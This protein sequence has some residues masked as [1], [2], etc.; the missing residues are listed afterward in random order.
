M[1]HPALLGKRSRVLT[2]DTPSCLPS[3]AEDGAPDLRLRVE[4]GHPDLWLDAGDVF[5]RDFDVESDEEIGDALVVEAALA[6]ET[7]FVGEHGD[8][9][10]GG[11]A[12]L[13][14]AGGFTEFA[15][16]ASDLIG[17]IGL[18]VLHRDLLTFCAA[19]RR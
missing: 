2:R 17:G 5:G 19:L 6:E 4:D 3:E 16:G 9:L 12:F 11:E 14:G 18:G 7:D 1:G 15:G 10:C 8:D 13:G